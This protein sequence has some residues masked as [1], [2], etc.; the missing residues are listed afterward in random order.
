MRDLRRKL[1]IAAL[2]V[3]AVFGG[4]AVPGTASAASANAQI[5]ICNNNGAALKFYI[6]GENDHGDWG[7]SRFWDVA[8]HGCTTASDYWWATNRAVEFHYVRPPKGW[9]WTQLYIPKAKNGSTK[10]F[11]IN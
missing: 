10:E 1:T 8:P 9:T 7:G 5:R 2:A 4:L 3:T 11:T 6:V